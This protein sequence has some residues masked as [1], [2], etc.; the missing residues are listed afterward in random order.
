MKRTV[1]SMMS[2][3]LCVVSMDDTLASVEQR[4]TDKHLSWAPVMEDRG[5]ILGVISAADLLRFHAEGGDSQAVRAWQMCT[6]KPITVGANADLRDV[7]RT[8]VDR[9]IHHVVVTE[10]GAAIGVLSSL[11]FVREFVATEPVAAAQK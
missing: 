6:F 11:D 3:D 1:S 2:R 4:L 10:G 8:M 9:G 7:A 5:A